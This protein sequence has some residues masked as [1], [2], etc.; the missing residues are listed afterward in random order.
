MGKTLIAIGCLFII[1]GL[2]FMIGDKFSFFG[3]GHLPGD[4]HFSKGDT[5][6]YF[7]IVSCILVSVVGTILLNLF[8]RK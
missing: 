3:L 7:P 8:F 1:A 6:F 4:I 2:L 5:D